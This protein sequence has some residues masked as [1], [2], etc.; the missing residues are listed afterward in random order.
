MESEKLANGICSFLEE[1]KAHDV[2]KIFVADKTVIADYFVI[3]GGRSQTQVRA[4]AEYVEEYIE[5]SGGEVKN[6]EGVA[7]GR[8]AVIDAGDVIVH[9]FDD[10]QRLFYHL[11]KLWGSA[12]EHKHD[13]VSE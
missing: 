5:K 9:V 8:W 1:K 2:V 7:E 6:T 11:E 10:E 3:A 4:L 13:S 12:D